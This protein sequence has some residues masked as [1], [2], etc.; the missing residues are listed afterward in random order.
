MGKPKQ[1]KVGLFVAIAFTVFF[2]AMLVHFIL[3]KNLW[4]CVSM[5]L[6]FIA[7]VCMIISLDPIIKDKQ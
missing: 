3:E 1:Q 5:A 2:G 4:M 7:S 6:L